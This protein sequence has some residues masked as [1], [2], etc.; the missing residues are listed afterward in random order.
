[1]LPSAAAEWAIH[2]AVGVCWRC[3]DVMEGPSLSLFRKE[4]TTKVTHSIPAC[5]DSNISKAKSK[6]GK[7]RGGGD[8]DGLVSVLCRYQSD[9]EKREANGGFHK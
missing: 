7:G 2:G 9:A 4:R 6:G 1:M 8:F 3:R 5:G